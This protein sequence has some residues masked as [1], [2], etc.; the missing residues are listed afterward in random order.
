MLVNRL[1]GN[2]YHGFGLNKLPILKNDLISNRRSHRFDLVHRNFT[3][4]SESQIRDQLR[5]V[6]EPLSQQPLLTVCGI[7]QITVDDEY[8]H[9]FVKLNI[10]SIGYP[11]SS[12]LIRKCE[13]SIH[14][15]P[16]VQFANVDLTY[17]ISTRKPQLEMTGLSKVQHVLAVSSCKGGV[18]EI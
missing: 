9:V 1:V 12:D 14:L 10:D 16:W 4:E 11:L 8:G 18:G 13:R 2:R 5:F 17:A 6:Q 15:L 3:L 7:Y